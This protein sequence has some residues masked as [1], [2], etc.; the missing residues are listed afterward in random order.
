MGRITISSLNRRKRE[1]QRISVLTAYDASFA[2]L[3]EA[4]GVEALLV[5]DS[6][7][8]VVQGRET[9]LPVTVDEMVYHTSL[10]ARGSSQA[11]LIA[12][13]P[14]MS[15]G[16]PELALHTAG[17]LMKVGGAHMVKLEGGRWIVDTVRYLTERSVP[18]CGHLGLLPQSIHRLGGY[19][20]Q[21]RDQAS[22]ETILADAQA[23]AGA[24]A[25]MLVLECVPL[26]L[27]RR[28]TET[29]DIPVIGIGAG[30]HCDGQVLVLYDMLGITPE[31]RP[32][33]TRDFLR[34]TGSVSGA[35]AAY[36]AAVRDGSFPGPE[37][38][39]R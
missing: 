23:L 37:H 10:V 33:F 31:P 15:H 38:C 28:I 34:E 17:Q 26:E 8:M 13:M 30:P 22:A 5:G 39:F 2:R 21:G 18:V 11:L 14:F 9:T 6:L 19:R 36:V 32:S 20:V 1:H 3:A 29:L 35:L 16:T 27:A 24:G 25:Q 7:G 12:D 4:A